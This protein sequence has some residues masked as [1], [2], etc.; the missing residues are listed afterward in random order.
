M[1]GVPGGC[2]GP[3]QGM[4]IA[5]ATARTGYRSGR[6]GFAAEHVAAKP[7]A[8]HEPGRSVAHGAQHGLQRLFRFGPEAKRGQAYS[9]SGPR[10]AMMRASIFLR[11]SVL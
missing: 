6:F 1:R 5:V 9:H 11:T 7:L 10:Q 8:R 3:Q 2:S 4:N